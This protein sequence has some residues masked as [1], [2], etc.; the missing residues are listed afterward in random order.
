M[1]F[2]TGDAPRSVRARSNL[3]AALEKLGCESVKPLQVDLL[4]HPEQSVSYSVFATPAL[5]R[6]GRDGRME[7]IYGDLSEE[8]KLL[9]FLSPLTEN[10]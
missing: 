4:E 6:T 8:R 7:T 10:R 9:D 3:S 2:I 5:L 1:L